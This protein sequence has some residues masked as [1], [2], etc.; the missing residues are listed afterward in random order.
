MTMAALHPLTGA[1]DELLEPDGV[2]RPAAAELVSH[3]RALGTAELQ[4]RQ[5]QADLDILAMGITFTVSSDSRGI[6]RAWPLDLVPRVIDAGEWSLLE[7]GLMQRLQAVNA[8]IDDVY[9]E[10]RI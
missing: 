2:P 4:A 6:D 7:G 1:W 5:D 8:F 9:N 3:L 10:R